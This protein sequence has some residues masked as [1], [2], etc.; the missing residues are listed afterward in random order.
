MQDPFHAGERA[1]QERVG[2][3][4]LAL[5]NGRAIAGSVSP[6][7]RTFPGKQQYCVIGW[8]AP[9]GDLWATLLTGRAG[10]AVSDANGSRVAFALEDAGEQ[11]RSHP[12]FDALRQRD[13]V[14]MLFIELATRR[15]LRINGTVAELAAASMTVNVMEAYPNC[16]KYIQRRAASRSATPPS[17][18]PTRSGS[19][20]TEETRRWIRSADTFFVATAQPQGLVD[21]SHRGGKAGF[22]RLVNGDLHIP[23][24]PGNSMFQTFGNL[25]LNPH[26]GL[27]FVDFEGNRQL[28][29]T[30][31]AR[32]DLEAGE[33][34]GETGGSG[35]WW[36]FSAR[37]WVISSL[38]VPLDWSA[39]DQS[40]FNP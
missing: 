32:L 7:A 36:V 10:F 21:C 28:Q 6:A 33:T 22:I 35:R 30:G 29:L 8:A 17:Y 16:P 24:Y 11:L 19:A 4:D 12:P 13:H 15:R 3:R 25:Y 31:E 9:Q 14:G 39:G 37:S 5:L 18:M 1:I 23:D 40:P 27:V 34:D 26:A 20:L 38:N 2:E